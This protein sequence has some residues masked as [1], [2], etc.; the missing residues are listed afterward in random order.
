MKIKKFLK[1]LRKSTKEVTYRLHVA[2]RLRL[3]KRKYVNAY[4]I[5]W[6]APQAS[7]WGP[8][9]VVARLNSQGPYEPW[10]AGQAAGSSL[11]LSPALY[12]RVA[13]ACRETDGHDAELRDLV[14][15]ACG[16]EVPLIKNR[17]VYKTEKKGK[18]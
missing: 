18:R 11:G 3:S 16:L 13:Q 17:T 4:A 10:L 15:N 7:L 9:E 14:L 8:I 1:L 5:Y 6:Q 12:T 2:G